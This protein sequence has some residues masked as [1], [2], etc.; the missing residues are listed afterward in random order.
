MGPHSGLSLR[1]GTG[2]PALHWNLELGTCVGVRG[3][4]FMRIITG[5]LRNAHVVKQLYRSLC[6][7]GCC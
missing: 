5:V 3:M 7:A 4:L 6:L 1:G 2:Y